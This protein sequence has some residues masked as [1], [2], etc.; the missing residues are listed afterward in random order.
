MRENKI[1]RQVDIQAHARESLEAK[2]DGA[3]IELMR[4]DDRMKGI[5][6]SQGVDERRSNM[7]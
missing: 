3:F 7:C 5:E 1:L 6:S 4:L 2:D